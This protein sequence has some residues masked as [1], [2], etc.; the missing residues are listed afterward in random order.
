MWRRPGRF[1]A[2]FL[3]AVLAGG[4]CGDDDSNPDAGLDGTADASELDGGDAAQPIGPP[5]EFDR[6]CRGQDWTES[7]TPA[8]VEELSGAYVGVYQDLPVGTQLTMKIVPKHPFRLSTVRAAFAGD[9]GTVR[10]HLTHSYGRSYP[11]IYREG[12]H[13]MNAFDYLVD[14]PDPETW[15]DIDVSAANLFLLPTQHYVIT[16]EVR[17]ANPY[18]AVE[19]LPA[20]EFSRAMMHIPGDSMPYGSDGNFRLQLTGS[21]FCAWDDGDRLFGEDTT[22]PWGEVASA[23]AAIADLNS[24]GHDDV[25]LNAGGPLAFFGDGQGHFSAP[26]FDPFPDVPKASMLVFADLDN[27]GH[28]DAFAANY[29]GADDDGD[30]FTKADGDCNDAD[31]NVHPGATEDLT[32]GLDDDCDGVTDDGS[33]LSDTDGDGFTITAGD[34][35]DNRDDVYPGAPE[36]LDGRDN[37]CDGEADEDFVNRILLNDGS[38]RFAALSGSGVEVLDHSTAAGFGDANGD[39]ALDL[40]WGNWLVHYPDDPAVQDRY[41]EGNGDGTF[42]D[43]HAAAGLT[44]AEPLSCYG[45]MWNDYNNDGF[46]DI[47][48]GNYHLYANQLWQNQG[49]GTFV[50]V[51][52]AVGVAYDDIPSMY[53]TWPGGHTY[54]GDFGDVD[55]DGDMDFFMA[56]LAHPRVQPWSDPSMF[57]I[58]SGPP[59]YT[60]ENRIHDYGFIYD[61]GDVNATF[62]DFDNDM[63]LDLVIATLYTGHYSKFYRN[64]GPD[65]FTDITYETGT[66]VH[67]AVS[68]VW[69]D[70]DEDG[71]LDLIIADRAGAPY[72]HLFLNRF[73]QDNNWVQLVLEG[74]TTNRG[75]IGARVTLTAGG[76]TQMRD[77][78]GGGGHSNT[79]SSRV[80]HFGLAQETTID[81][82]TVR[83]VGGSTEAISGLS[84]NGRFRVVE[85]TGTAQAL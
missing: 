78:R 15:L 60:F 14:D 18:L 53:P 52:A 12:G 27:D 29:V 66:A 37:D 61:E 34:C 23:R 11:D 69:S 58:N 70:V 54:G 38:G 10:V 77:I 40:Y 22:Q 71:D 56:N 43:A 5:A 81:S 79:Q 42:T 47:F 17:E 76:V 85:G 30:G 84:P 50:D 68:V 21:Y 32:N 7:L 46:Q 65:G 1:T 48:V 75:A 44:L 31:E 55:N 24:D 63:D 62:A 6:F 36:L 33:D 64:D 28:V 8:V 3:C 45:V 74:T 83:W 80:V 59:D 51:A 49:D 72:V 67:D 4:A 2:V 41:F 73:G 16:I 82:V 35:D 25:I 20:G 9:P 57:V 26:G 19:D 39:G 13:L